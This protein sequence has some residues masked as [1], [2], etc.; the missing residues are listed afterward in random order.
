MVFVCI[1][2]V[3]Y[4]FRSAVIILFVNLEFVKSKLGSEFDTPGLKYCVRY[5][6]EI[7]L[8]LA[9]KSQSELIIRAIL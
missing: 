2:S 8:H 5:L 1:V 4:C 9:V 7:K 3:I 6:I